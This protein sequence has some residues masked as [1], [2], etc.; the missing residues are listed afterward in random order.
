MQTNLDIKKYLEENGITQAFVSK[1][2]GISRSKLSIG[3][4]KLTIDEYAL[5][6]G[7]LGVNTDF[8]VKPKLP[9][10]NPMDFAGDVQL[11]EGSK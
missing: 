6:C 3:E 1:K 2:T 4:R 9:D 10:G 11:G 7:A 8:F 5:I